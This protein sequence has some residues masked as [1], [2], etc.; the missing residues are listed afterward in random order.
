MESPEI[1][2][3]RGTNDVLA[4]LSTAYQ[5]LASRWRQQFGLYGYEL[6]DTPVLEPTDLFLRKSGEEVAAR[7]YAF[8]HW[9]RDICLRPE[10]TASVIRAYVNHLQD[11]PLPVRLQYGGPTFRYEKPQRG[12]DRQFTEVGVECIGADGPAAD[13]E[14]LAV[15]RNGLEAVG[16]HNA[17]YVVG[18]LG[19][20]LQLLGQLGMEPR[21]Q[22]LVLGVMEH[23]SRAPGETERVVE[24]LAAMLG[25][26]EEGEDG[27]RD[28]DPLGELVRSFG[29]DGAARIASNLL[30]RASLS[31]DGGVRSPEEIVERLLA[32]TSRT[33]PTPALARAVEFIGQL[34]EAAGPPATALP[35]LRRVLAAHGLS[36]GPVHEVEQALAHFAAYSDEPAAVEVDLSLARGLRYYTGL[37]FE[38]YDVEGNQIAGGGRYDDLVRALGGR[39]S[40]PACGFSYGLERVIAALRRN[41]IEPAARQPASDVLVV[42]MES[43]DYD[44][45]AHAASALRTAGISVEMDVRFRGL[46]A[47]LRHADHQ[48]IPMVLIVG[49][50]EREAGLL[51]LRDMY[52]RDE[53]RIPPAEIVPAVRAR[54]DRVSM[55]AAG[56]R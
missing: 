12:R 22:S 21:A 36:D 13:A 4:P 49:E 27:S 37:V 51:G 5:E 25:A 6:I 42:P 30:E 39:V 40:V 20:V 47:N 23:L 19:A 26:G 46:K 56:A 29:H 2:R 33:D 24:R 8:T 15:A 17:R 7:T 50:R 43:A 48:L 10:F 31:L 32:K 18:H 45:A 53:T 52:A 44:L 38:V 35:A 41:Q 16:L 14:V 28:G 1:Q 34:R 11:R 54:L 3:I 9:N 55:E